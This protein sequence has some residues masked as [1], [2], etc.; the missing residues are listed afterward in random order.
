MINKKTV[1]IMAFCLL[2]QSLLGQE[3]MLE[4]KDSLEPTSSKRMKLELYFR[5]GFISDKHTQERLSSSH[6][7]IDNAR[8]NFQGDYN[9]D[10]SYRVRFRLNRPLSPTSQ[11]N[12]S[13]GLDYAYL[14]YRFGKQ[15][16]WE[17]MVGKQLSAM[18]SFEQDINPLYEYIFTDY[19]NGVYANVFLAG[20]QLTYKINDQH[21]IGVQLHNTLNE[22][23]SNHLSNNNFSTSDYTA[24]K[25]PIGAYFLWNAN[26]FK[27]KFKTKY[28]YNI[29]QF[30]QGYYT[31]SL[32][33]GNKFQSDPHT[34]YLDLVYS[35]MGA[36]FGLTSSRLLSISDG[37]VEGNY[38]MRKNI[39]YKC[40]VS[41]Y[42]YQIDDH[43][44]ATAKIG[45]ELTGSRN[46]HNE[47]LR[48]NY[49]YFLAG[50]YAPFRT[51]DLRFYI[52]YVGNTIQ[53]AKE[54]AMDKE[55]LHRF[56][57]GAYF[58]LPILKK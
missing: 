17:A 58:T 23:F 9:E 42:D 3:Q 21:K 39:V 56:A 45:V 24:S 55:Q 44:S 25:A 48:T 47:Q 1:V 18:G 8:L 14:S 53:Y 6:F 7:Q 5:G 54:L 27:G 57:I 15:K 12:A 36:D 34:V 43:W 30:A 16:R 28:T 40:A 33:L 2:G 13:V 38:T 29:S 50:Q 46:I 31:H 52:A 37:L 51:Q 32:S 11:D 41:R 22:S 35:H 4:K 26:L 10:L 19:L 20:V 49:I